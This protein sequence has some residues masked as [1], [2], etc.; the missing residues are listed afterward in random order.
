HSICI[1]KMHRERSS[2]E[3]LEQKTNCGLDIFWSCRTNRIAD[4]DFID[5]Q[6]EERARHVSD[7]FFGDDPLV[8]AHEACRNITSDGHA[9][10]YRLRDNGLAILYR[11]LNSHVDV[12]AIE[13]LRCSGKDGNAPNA[14]LNGSFQT[15]QVWDKRRVSDA[16]KELNP[17]Y[18]IL[19]VGQLRNPL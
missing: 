16:R 14:A 2:R 1:V 3:L 15:L 11:F 4:R 9:S 10:R 8:W 19:G 12:F 13:R 6:L 5:A 17:L 18:E 7:V